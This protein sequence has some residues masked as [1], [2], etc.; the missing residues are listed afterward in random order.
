MVTC[1]QLF[2]T[3]VEW[4]EFLMHG[5]ETQHFW[6]INGEWSPKKWA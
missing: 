4:R 3:S 6:C 2:M 5:D 1:G